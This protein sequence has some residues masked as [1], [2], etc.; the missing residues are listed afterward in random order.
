MENI[1]GFAPEWAAQGR[2]VHC[3]LLNCG[4][5]ASVKFM[6]PVTPGTS[7]CGSVKDINP[8]MS[9]S[10]TGNNLFLAKL[11]RCEI[12]C[13]SNLDGDKP[14]QDVPSCEVRKLLHTWKGEERKKEKEPQKKAVNTGRVSQP[15]ERGVLSK[16]SAGF[17]PQTWL[18]GVCL[19]TGLIFLWTQWTLS[20]KKKGLAQNVS[21]GRNSAN[22]IFVVCCTQGQR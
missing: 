16:G 8:E 13:W 10:R 1:T 5:L 15:L 11:L 21:Q 20:G 2:H 4:L 3:C 9:L 12:N 6:M 19:G 17:A 18:T 7:A 22:S 14:Y